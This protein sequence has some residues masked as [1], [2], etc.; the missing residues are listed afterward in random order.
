MRV[1][2]GTTAAALA[3]LLIAGSAPAAPRNYDCSK[4]GNANKAACKAPASPAAAPAAPAAAPAPA[5]GIQ[6]RAPL[7]LQQARQRQEGD[8]QERCGFIAAGERRLGARHARVA[9]AHDRAARRTS[10]SNGPTSR[11][12]R[13]ARSWRSAKD[14]P[15]HRE[16]RQG[17]ALRLLQ[18]GQLHQEGLASSRSRS[19]RVS[20]R[21][22]AAALTLTCLGAA[23]AQDRSPDLVQALQLRPDQE[24][25][26]AAYLKAT[27]PNPASDARRSAE[28]ARLANMTTPQRFDW[29]REQVAADLAEMDAEGTCGE[30]LLCA[31]DARAAAHLRRQDRSGIP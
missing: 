28:S 9:A 1:L 17:G 22:A 23:Q 30:A 13:D 29:T 21:V 2:I 12:F 31:A 16:E 8:L 24:A 4:A 18:G 7:R 10:S 3:T 11:S 5:R 14:R 27:A 19:V 26:F 15:L 20:A 6:D 25:A